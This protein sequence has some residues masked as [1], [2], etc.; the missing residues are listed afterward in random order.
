MAL[1]AL[2]AKSAKFLRAGYPDSAP[3]TGYVPV[4]ALLPRRLS[5]DEVFGLAAEFVA[6]GD[7]R[8]DPADIGAAIT[9]LT[10][11]MPAPEDIDRIGHRLRALQVSVTVPY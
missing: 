8:V 2:V 9:R 6:R 3:P 10:R 11:E 5:D 1:L 4:L 7:A